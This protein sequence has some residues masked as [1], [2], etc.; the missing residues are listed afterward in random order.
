MQK[1]VGTDEELQQAAT[2]YFCHALSIVLGRFLFV[3]GG[4]IRIAKKIRLS[5][6][7]RTATSASPATPGACAGGL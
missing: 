4:D 7:T 2:D 1:I 6:P 5:A 3:K